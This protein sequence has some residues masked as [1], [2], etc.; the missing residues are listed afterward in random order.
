MMAGFTGNERITAAA[1]L[2]R[3]RRRTVNAVRRLFTVDG[4]APIG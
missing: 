1:R 4:L 3:L 2:D